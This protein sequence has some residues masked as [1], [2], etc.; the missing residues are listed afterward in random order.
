MSLNLAAIH[1]FADSRRPAPVPVVARVETPNRA[2]GIVVPAQRKSE[3]I[4]SFF[5]EKG[6]A[7][8]LGAG[9]G[10]MD[11]N[12]EPQFF[13][14]ASNPNSGIGLVALTALGLNVAEL[15]MLW[16]GKSPSKMVP[17][18][19]GDLLDGALHG[20]ATTSL[21]IWGYKQGNL[22]QMAKASGGTAKTKGFEPDYEATKAFAPAPRTQLSD[23]ERVA[24]AR[25]RGRTDPHARYF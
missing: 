2:D 12:G 23:D 4:V 8:L 20:A 14:T 15:G 25:E 22:Y 17:G 21:G 16:F 3:A 13:S 9:L 5:G 18:V 10:M 7:L 1:A 11:A 19:A 6:A 24:A